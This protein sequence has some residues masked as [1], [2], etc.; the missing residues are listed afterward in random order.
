[1]IT[2]EENPPFLVFC[3]D[4]SHQNQGLCALCQQRKWVDPFVGLTAKI[5]VISHWIDNDPVNRDRDPEALSW[6]RVTKVCEEAGEV[7]AEWLRF[8]GGNP[9]KEPST[10]PEAVIKELLDVAVSALCGVEHL[11]GH[12]GKSVQMMDEKLDFVV[13]RAGLG[14]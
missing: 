11:I 9:R 7:W 10:S 14:E 12:T 8:V 13:N 2:I 5:C 3:P 1:M 4:P 6:H